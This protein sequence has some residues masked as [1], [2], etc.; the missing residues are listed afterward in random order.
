MLLSQERQAALLPLFAVL[1]VLTMLALLVSFV[2][3]AARFLRT[4]VLQQWQ[5][6]DEC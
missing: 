5:R 3:L 2:L 4:G 6:D 1:T